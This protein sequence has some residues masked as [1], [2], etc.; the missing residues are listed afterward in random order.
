MVTNF[1]LFSNVWL[2]TYSF[3][4]LNSF[5]VI[6]GH[7]IGKKRSVVPLSLAHF[8]EAHKLQFK[9]SST[10]WHASWGITRFKYDL[11]RHISHHHAHNLTSD[12]YRTRQNY[13]FNL[14]RSP[15]YSS[16]VA[17][18][19]LLWNRFLVA[20]YHTRSSFKSLCDS[21]NCYYT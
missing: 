15:S 17:P 19:P 8:W 7:T 18:L 6:Y 10:N 4:F 1:Y 20:H 14:L 2:R 3:F 21:R 12:A 5:S 16:H 9:S 11:G 13:I